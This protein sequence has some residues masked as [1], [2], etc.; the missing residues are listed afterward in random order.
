MKEEQNKRRTELKY[1]KMKQKEEEQE[2]ESGKYM[3]EK[4]NRMHVKLNQ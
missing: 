4:K 1:K 3:K 2:K